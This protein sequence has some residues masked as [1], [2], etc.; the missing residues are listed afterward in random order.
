MMGNISVHRLTMEQK[1]SEKKKK[2]CPEQQENQQ[3]AMTGSQGRESF[4]K[5]V[6]NMVKCWKEKT[7]K[8]RIFKSQK[9]IKDFA[10]AISLD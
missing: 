8:V 5:E 6:S 2:K 3:S 1:E 10:R 9:V 4:W 7:N